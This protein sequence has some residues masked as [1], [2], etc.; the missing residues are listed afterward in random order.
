[1]QINKSSDLSARLL[2]TENLQVVRANARTAYFDIK[3]RVLTLPMWKEMTSDIEDMLIGHEVGH[4][5]FTSNEYVEPIL[6]N[7]KL[8]S[9]MNIVEDV[10]IEKLIKRKY[11][12]LRKR[13]NEGY[14]QLNDRDFFGVKTI[15]D[16]NQ[17]LLIDKINLYFKVG[18]N[19]GVKFNSDEKEFVNRIERAET[20]QEVIQLAQ[21]IYDYS[22]EKYEE[23]QQQK[24]LRQEGIPSSDEDDFADAMDGLDEEFDEVLGGSS[25]PKQNLPTKKEQEDQDPLESKTDKVFQNKLED[26]ADTN[27]VYKYWKLDE[28]FFENPVVPFSTILKETKSVEQWNKDNTIDYRTVNLSAEQRETYFNKLAADYTKFINDSSSTVNYLVKEFEM[29][30][31]A[32]LYKRAAVAKVGS[33]DMRKIYAYKIKDDIFK[34]TTTLPQG[35][36]HGMVMLLDWSGSMDSVINDTLK[37]VIN[38][39]MFCQRSQ[40]PFR[41]YAFTTEYVPQ[42]TDDERVER[43]SKKRDWIVNKRKQNDLL[44][45]ASNGFNLLELFS[46]RMTKSEFNS[47]SKRVLDYRFFSNRGYGTSGTPLNESLSWIYMNLDKFIKEYNVEKTTFITLTDGEGASLRGMNTSLESNAYTDN[48]RV[49]QKHFI[50]EETTHKTYE[51]KHD[52]PQQTEVILRMIKDR[53]SVNVVGFYICHNSRRDLSSFIRCNI[54]EYNGDHETLIDIWRKE[55]RANNFSSVKNTGRDELFLIPQ[56]ST[57][58]EEGEL[59]INASAKASSIAK[60]FGK[61]LNVKKTSRVLL[62]RFVDLIA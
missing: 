5:L 16:L 49:R 48:G 6:K 18:F 56:S 25:Q 39:V 45:N 22:K 21:E 26:L 7:P 19:C 27:T 20:V 58:I 12:G 46:D 60:G 57:K 4:A 32:E 2:A 9:Y 54:P 40:I 3:S 47:M 14:K 52:A 30:K 37:Q 13:M 44:S 1:M 33:L 24:K 23:E 11:P 61:Y 17:L 36:N 28:D 55:F 10:R 50:R 34:R 15:P 53:Y 59:D 42:T 38:L 43:Y 29:K 35:K 31:S 62:S 51:I 41:V 8:M